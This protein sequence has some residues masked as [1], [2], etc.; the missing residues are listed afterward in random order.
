MQSERDRERCGAV[1][2]LGDGGC[3][4]VKWEDAL[5]ITRQH[6]AAHGCMTPHVV[7]ESENTRTERPNDCTQSSH[8]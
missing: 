8:R 1:T 6:H 4:T 7:L 2:F 5:P 3:E